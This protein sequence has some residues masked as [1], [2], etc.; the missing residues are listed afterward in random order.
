MKKSQV[1]K[2]V[3]CDF[4]DTK[5]SKL[6]AMTESSCGCQGPGTGE[7]TICRGAPGNMWG[8]G[9]IF[10]LDCP[11]SSVTVDICQN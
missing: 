1:Q 9:Y 10:Y 11:S 6:Q 7:K 2:T 5:F 8:H 4:I 3:T